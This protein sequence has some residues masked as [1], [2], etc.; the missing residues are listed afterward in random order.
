MKYRI[1]STQE[2]NS[3]LDGRTEE[4]LPHYGDIYQSAPFLL[5]L[6][7]VVIFP[8]FLLSASLG[9]I[10]AF[11]LLMTAPVFGVVFGVFSFKRSRSKTAPSIFTGFP[12]EV[13]DESEVKKAA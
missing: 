6:I 2:T 12:P 13:E 4:D 8:L 1:A 7:L 9:S 11:L 10:L 5:W 3:E